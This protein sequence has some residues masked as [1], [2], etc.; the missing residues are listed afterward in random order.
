[1]MIHNGVLFV[2]K[3]VMVMC[4]LLK[5]GFIVHLDM[6]MAFIVCMQKNNMM[7]LLHWK[8]DLY[9]GVFVWENSKKLLRLPV[10]LYFL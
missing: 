2:I 8:L 1:M 3:F 6:V 5:T 10:Y 4:G 7:K 9:K